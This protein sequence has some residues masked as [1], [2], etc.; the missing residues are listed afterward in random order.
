[1][2]DGHI[3]FDGLNE[4][5]DEMFESSAMHVDTTKGITAEQLSK[6]GRV[7]NE[8]SQQSIGCDNTVEQS[9]C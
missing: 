8:V 5:D 3:F 6:L 7:S 1:M 4:I 2:E 9:G